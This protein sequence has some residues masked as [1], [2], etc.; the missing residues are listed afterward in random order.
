MV[1]MRRSHILLGLFFLLA[2]SVEAEVPPPQVW[3][4]FDREVR[5]M[6]DGSRGPYRVASG[7]VFDVH[8]WVEDVLQVPDLDYVLD[9]ERG[10]ITFLKHIVRGENLLIRYKKKPQIVGDVYRRRVLLESEKHE[11]GVPF[12]VQRSRRSARHYDEEKL[13]IGGSKRIAVSFGSAQQ[14]QV[15]QALQLHI[16]GEVAE[17]VSLLAVLSDRNLPVGEKGATLGLRELDRILFQVRGPQVSADVG[18]LDVL[19]DRTSF[20]RYRRQLQGAQVSF[21]RGESRGSVVGAVSRGQW[22]THR[23]VGIEGYQGPYQLPVAVGFAGGVLPESE[24]VYLNGELLKRGEQLDYVLDYEQGSVTFAP[25]R[26]IVTSSRIL[27]EYQTYDETQQSRLVGLDGVVYLGQSG[28]SVGA[29]LIRENNQSGVLSA[30]TGGP[31]MHRQ[32]T[33]LDVMYTPREDVVLRSEVSW[34]DDAQRKGHAVDVDGVWTS[35]W[36]ENQEVQV[37]G[38][39][40]QVSVG[41]EGFE[42]LDVGRLEGRWGWQNDLRN[43]DV[44]EGEVGIRYRLG[45]A[46]V[47][48]G[49]GRQ[50]GQDVVTRRDVGFELPFGHYVFEQFDLG[51]GGLTRQR[52]GVL[53]TWG[54]MR[55]GVD[56]EME[57][58]RGEGVARSSVFYASD[59]R[60]GDLNGVEMAEVSWHG[61]VDGDDWQWRTELEGRRVRQNETMWADSLRAWSHRHQA[62]FDLGGWSVSGLYGQTVS[63]M[64]AVAK[65]R[66]VTHLGRTR[67]HYSGRGYS[68]QFFYRVSSAGVQTHQPV[69]VEVGRGLG[70]YAWE[71]V[72]GDGEKDPEEFVPDVDGNYEPVYA[73]GGN[74]RPVREGVMGFRLETDLGKLL[75]VE[76]GFVSGISVDASLNAERQAE[77][78]SVGPWHL[79]GV[80]ENDDVQ[81]AQRDLRL[82]LYVFR[83]HKRGSLFTSGRWRDRVDRIFYGG[84]RESV[85]QGNVGGRLRFGQPAE[86]EGDVTVES[87]RRSGAE[88]FA[89]AIHAYAGQVRGLW[90]PSR[91]WDMRLGVLG[92]YDTEDQ[93]DL[94]VQYYS[95][96][97]EV[98]RRLS[99][100]GRMRARLD[101]TRV[102][103]TGDVP[104]FLGMAQGNR[105][106]QNWVWRLGVD[107]RLGKYVTALVSYDGRKRPMLPAI[108]LGRMEMRAV[109]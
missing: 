2:H 106:G 49:W 94:R 12:S 65:T 74:F 104:I 56:F 67:V 64:G 105:V 33:G 109:F 9:S 62:K 4:L 17:G 84:G 37:T 70:T 30:Q 91:Q 71:D 39:F 107:Y 89:F 76:K 80:P 5:L 22:T 68:Q 103:A 60:A 45:R 102:W 85:R 73:T 101:W 108:H 87:R 69:Y 72:D 59:P 19:F 44:R 92:G 54:L 83:Y 77:S 40:R 53:G 88:A 38:R 13:E 93:R 14:H 97:P 35:D 66:R 95:L 100:R 25:E 27:V 6:G 86:L 52:G 82:R 3:T 31:G 50:N 7:L 8:V 41:Y 98:I 24:R 75:Q 1:L 11:D 26:P 48:G 90:R 32:V 57:R 16:A 99:G 36:Q 43:Q 46:T 47:R 28:W 63:D 61:Q 81:M 55:L 23:L 10:Q 34:S 21:D 51:Q 18:D 20:G 29:T 15:S 96:Q 42:R 79:F 58:A 78:N